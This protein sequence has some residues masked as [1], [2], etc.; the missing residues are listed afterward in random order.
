MFA[1]LDAT[2]GMEDGSLGFPASIF[3]IAMPL[4][5]SL[6]IGDFIVKVCVGL[7]ALIPYGGL[8]KITE[9]KAV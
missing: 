7:F 6:A 1:G 8:L 5:A 9:T 2:F 4:W 3:G